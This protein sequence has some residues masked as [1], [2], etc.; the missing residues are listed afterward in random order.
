MLLNNIIKLK[1]DSA[2]DGV[3]TLDNFYNKMYK[4]SNKKAP[5]LKKGYYGLG[6]HTNISG[7]SVD[8]GVDGAGADGGGGE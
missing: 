6:G 3:P 8:T 2:I 1:V 7:D 5:K 4:K